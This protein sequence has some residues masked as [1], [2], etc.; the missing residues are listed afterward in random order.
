M[1]PE[2]RTLILTALLVLGG[3][4]GEPEEPSEPKTLV[5]GMMGGFVCPTENMVLRIEEAVDSRNK[6]KMDLLLEQGCTRAASNLT[7]T[8]I[9]GSFSRTTMNVRIEGKSVWAYGDTLTYWT[10]TQRDLYEAWGECVERPEYREDITLCMPEYNAM[11]EGG[12]R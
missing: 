9:S 1:Q 11:D 2:I 12:L 8:F 4:G 7:A 10:D 6:P 3:C 5:T